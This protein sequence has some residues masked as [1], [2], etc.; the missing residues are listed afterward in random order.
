[1][2][3]GASAKN[4]VEIAWEGPFCFKDLI[5]KDG[6]RQEFDVPG[7]YLCLERCGGR[8]DVRGGRSA[9]ALPARRLNRAGAFRRN[10]AHDRGGATHADATA[11]DAREDHGR[12]GRAIAGQGW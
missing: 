1:M 2:N 5:T 9:A 4:L 11:R 3:A 7:V 10:S 12:E 8:S 6:I